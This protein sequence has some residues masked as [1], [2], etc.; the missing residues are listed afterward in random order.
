MT[1]RSCRS[2]P[3]T[4]TRH[5]TVRERKA[6][7]ES[8]RGGEGDPV[9]ESS[10]SQAARL[11]CLRLHPTCRCIAAARRHDVMVAEC[12][13][14]VG[15]R[16]FPWTPTERFPL[17]RIFQDRGVQHPPTPTGKHPVASTT[18]RTA[19]KIR[20]GR[21]ERRIRLRQYTSTVG[22]NPSSSNRSPQATFQAISRRNALMASRSLKPSSACSTITVAMTSAG[23]DG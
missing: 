3:M 18:W 8:A 1:G 13:Q 15:K 5:S 10:D 21:V 16:A 19:S 2:L 17:D 20:R 14:Q 9:G 11:R 12:R 7:R 22:W 6:P 23:T 4:M